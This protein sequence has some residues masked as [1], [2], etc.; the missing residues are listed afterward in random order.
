MT[1]PMTPK[2]ERHEAV[3]N[4]CRIGFQPVQI[5]PEA[6]AFKPTQAGCLCYKKRRARGISHMK[7]LNHFQRLQAF[8]LESL[9]LTTEEKPCTNSNSF[10]H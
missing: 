4:G 3:T 5:F 2:I 7:T 1:S 6:E 8:C 9:P 10:S